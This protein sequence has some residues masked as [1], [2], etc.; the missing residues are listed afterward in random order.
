MPSNQWLLGWQNKPLALKDACDMTQIGHHIG[1][2]LT[3]SGSTGLVLQHG[4][5]GGNFV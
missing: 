5:A 1:Q 4:M 3:S 2:C